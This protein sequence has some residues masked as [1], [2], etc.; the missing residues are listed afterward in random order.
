MR[1]INLFLKRFGDLLVSG[2]LIIIL[3]PLLLILALLIKL[4][5]KGPAVFTQ[6][7]VGKKGKIF[8]IYKFRTMLIPEQRKLPDGSE[9]APKD[10]ITKVGKFLRKTS[11]DELMQLF[12]VFFGSMSIVGPRPT[13]PYQVER[14]TEEQKK[15]MDM[16]P[17]VTGWAQVN[18]R[19]NLSW[20]EKIV[21]DLQ[22]VEKFSIWFDI[23]I[24]F[25][26]VGVVFK[27]EGTQYREADSSFKEDNQKTKEQEKVSKKALVLCGG[28]PQI[29]LLKQLKER[30]ITSVLCDM[31]EKVEA[32]KHADIFY[33]VSTLDVEKVTQV[34][35][36]EK[37][38]FLITVCADQ[39]LE[40]VAEISEKLSL[41]CYIDYQTA[42]NVSDKELMKDIFVKNGVPTSQ[43]V[44]MKELS[45]DKISHLTYPL[46]VK[47]VDSYSSM[48]VKKIEK[49]EDL[50]P[51][52]D[53]AIRISRSKTAL[54]E[55]FV[56]GEEVTVDVY[57][58]EGV[59]N[60]L[61][62]SNSAKIKGNNKFVINRTINPA[63]ISTELEGEITQIAQKIADAFNLKNTPMLVQLI[64]DGKRISV[65]EFCAR[66][67]GGIKFR[68]IKKIS[69]FDVVKA[70]L[71]LTLGEKPHYD[72]ESRPP[73]QYLINEFIYCNSGTFD[74]I[75]GF[76]E[77]K[78]EGVITEYYQ[79]KQKGHEFKTISASGDRAACF[80][81]EAKT[82]EELF[83]KHKIAVSR[84]KIV[85][86]NGV[87]IKK[88][89]IMHLA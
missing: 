51:A 72:K 42:K 55:E 65:L 15:R 28:V 39:V 80:T 3:S 14:Y 58:E 20:A 13:L 61:T 84:V 17:G 32:R 48:G 76:E 52:F 49:E 75:E 29:E 12:N 47:P 70:V 77:L 73:K 23:K 34:A 18:G 4:T 66:T 71:D 85:D 2:L 43:H 30:G 41:P 60:V 54:V 38:D 11:L 5:S 16:R 35:I 8:K 83:E 50:Q 67:G 59:A 64:T 81:V 21:F 74:H 24:L 9:L 33:P 88:E 31:N 22:Y 6:E 10:S 45:L 68:L 89:D 36:K 44:V 25:K 26:T 56:E 87:D 19:N 82:Q 57:V 27:K 63:L 62:M 86:A 7:R 69:G 1:A 79:L 37:V 46:I 40:V 78:Q 53:E